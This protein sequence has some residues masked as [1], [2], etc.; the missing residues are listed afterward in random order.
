VIAMALK[1]D[2]LRRLFT[3]YEQDDWL[4]LS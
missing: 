2:F 1:L 3:M 4:A